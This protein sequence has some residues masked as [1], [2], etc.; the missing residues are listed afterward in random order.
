VA[1]GQSTNIKVMRIMKTTF[2]RPYQTK[3]NKFDSSHSILFGT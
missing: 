3:E 2:Q 1:Q